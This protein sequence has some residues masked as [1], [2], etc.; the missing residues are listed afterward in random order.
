MWRKSGEVFSYGCL[1]A[2]DTDKIN[3]IFMRASERERAQS[4]GGGAA[5][6]VYSTERCA[7]QQQALVQR[8]INSRLRHQKLGQLGHKPTVP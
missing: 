8:R 4:I 2:C 1:V 5:Y 7:M 6:S 3:Y